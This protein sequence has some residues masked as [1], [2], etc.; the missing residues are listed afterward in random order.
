MAVS[1][2]S[3]DFWKNP[4]I[5]ARYATGGN[6]VQQARFFQAGPWLAK[7]PIKQGETIVDVGAGTGEITMLF[8]TVNGAGQN[9][10]VDYSDAMVTVAHR[11][12]SRAKISNLQ[13][14]TSDATQ[15]K[16]PTQEGTVHRMISFSAIH[17][18]P[19]LQGFVDGINKYLAPGGIFFFR[20]AG[21]KG[22]ETLELAEKISRGDEWKEKFKRFACPMHTHS[23]E[24]MQ[25]TLEKVG[26]VWEEA[27]IW[28]NIETFDNKQGYKAYVA[29]W[30][31]HLYHLN[32]EDRE[33]FLNLVVEAH[34]SRPERRNDKGE[35][36]VWDTQVKV[37]GSKPNK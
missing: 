4:D 15:L 37:T 10:A 35:I 34:C 33:T 16:L 24:V 30:L 27:S 9:Y 12:I 2:C 25:A 18:F 21:C 23:P 17:W 28:R 5:V 8:A 14:W 26:L 7:Y 11:K 22:D 6:V 29:G 13:V 19:N 3:Q 1:C 32:D 31:P 20:Y 36:T